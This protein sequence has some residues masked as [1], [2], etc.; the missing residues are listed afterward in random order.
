MAEIAVKPTI[1]Y[2]LQMRQSIGALL[3]H[4]LRSILLH[5]N[6][7]S[8]PREEVPHMESGQL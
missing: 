5:Q 1:L 3:K 7:H 8:F 6:D 4:K 2:T